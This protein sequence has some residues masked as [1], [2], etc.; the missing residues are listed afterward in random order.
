MTITAT[1]SETCQMT[2]AQAIAV[3]RKKLEDRIITCMVNDK[4]SALHNKDRYVFKLSSRGISGISI[5]AVRRWGIRRVE[6][7]KSSV[8]YFEHGQ[9]IMRCS[10]RATRY[11]DMLCREAELRLLETTISS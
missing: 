5:C 3:M 8:Y 9:Y 1:V 7:R 11:Y 6:V 4:F 2:N 10:R